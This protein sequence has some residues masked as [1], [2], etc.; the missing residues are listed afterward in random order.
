[1]F[2]VTAC[3][4]WWGSRNQKGYGILTRKRRQLRAT[5]LVWE[6]CFGL[7]PDGMCVLHRCDN[8]PCVN[9][10]HLFLGTKS[11]NNRDA[12]AKGRSRGKARLTAEQV[13]SIRE[14]DETQQA[15]GDRYGI[16]QSSVSYIQLGKSYKWCL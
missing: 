10:E 1:M 8:P 16:S 15:L 4:P 11:D 5:R 6:E 12:A 9:P 2:G 3:L 13:R 7:I 14:S